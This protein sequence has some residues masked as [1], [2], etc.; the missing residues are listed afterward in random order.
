MQI[1]TVRVGNNSMQVRILAPKCSKYAL[2]CVVNNLAVS[3]NAHRNEAKIIKG[4]VN[5]MPTFN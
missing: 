5:V 2:N 4:V 3:T 1:D